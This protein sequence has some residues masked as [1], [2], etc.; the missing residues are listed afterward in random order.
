MMYN[1]WDREHDQQNFSHFGPFFTLLHPLPIPLTTQR[2][3]ILKKWKK[4]LQIWLLSYGVH[5]TEFW[6]IFYPLTA[7]KMKISKKWKNAWRYHFT[8]VY[9]KSW[10]M[11][12]N[13][14]NCYFSFW[15]ILF[16][17]PQPPNSPKNE[18]FKKMKKRLEISSFYTSVPKIM[19]IC[20]TVSMVCDRCN[21]YFIL[22]YFFY[23]FTPITAQKMKISKKMEKS[24]EISS[25]YKIVPK[26][27]MICYTG[28]DIWHMINV[29]IFHFDLFFAL[30]PP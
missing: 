27:M 18:N 28:P 13:G 9:Q 25:F 6:V 15:A 20:Y 30:L 26:I 11:A 4:H 5:Q 22:G 10:D 19:I 17:L 12:R 29:I 3:I 1:S 7:W 14:C 8:Q 24:L 2:I 23:P 21:C 16:P